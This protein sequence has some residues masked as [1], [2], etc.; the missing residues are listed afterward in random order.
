[1]IIFITLCCGCDGTSKK[2]EKSKNPND[3]SKIKDEVSINTDAIIKPKEIV[4]VKKTDK[5]KYLLTNGIKLTDKEIACDTK[6]GTATLTCIQIS[7]L[8]DKSIE[9]RLN[10]AIID[11]LEIEVKNYVLEKDIK[12]EALR[13]FYTNA[14]LNANN[15]LS[16][17]LVYF[18]S[19]PIYGLLYRLT[20][21][22]RLYLKDIFTAGT[23]YVS[24]LNTKVIEGIIGEVKANNYAFDG[25]THYED[26]LK[27]PFSTINPNQN[28]VLSNSNLY[29]VFLP[30]EGGFVSRISVPIALSSIDDYVDVTD[31]YSGTERKNHLYTDLIIRHNNNFFT[32][33]SNVI[34]RTNGD[35]WV[36]YNEI[37]GIRNDSLEK[38]INTTIKTGVDETLKEKYLDSLAKV[39]KTNSG[40]DFVSL[41][42]TNPIFNNYGILCI[43]KDVLGNDYSRNKDL[44]KLYTVYSF[45]LIKKKL[46]NTKMILSDYII[47]NTVT[48]EIFTNLVKE[49]LR[50][51]LTNIH[52][53]NIDEICSK[54][55]YSLIKEK[56]ILYFSGDSVTEI[57]VY[58]KQANIN[59]LPSNMD[60]H[61]PLSKINKS[62]AEDFFGW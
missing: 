2:P 12:G 10:K 53:S 54:V 6:N 60:C 16:V 20:D 45:D 52:A 29:I 38:I 42:R 23:D 13:Y 18:Y 36:D 9:N 48:E 35:I 14:V 59:G 34:K 8:K 58:F 26:F 5:T 15:L 22:E 47:K 61:F 7:G 31:R 24:L 27:E 28:F 3:A 33:I 43:E 4:L 17:S 37:S 56:S 39:P 41:I 40:K 32:S 25:I 44:D 49:S 21:G 46:L 55:S 51:E 57:N 50:K 1:M 11:N 30:G 19:E 62:V